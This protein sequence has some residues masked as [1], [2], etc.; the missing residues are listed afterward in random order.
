M[1]HLGTPALAIKEAL[2]L[3]E[4][5]GVF[6]PGIDSLQLYVSIVALSYFHI[7]NAPT[8]S[9]LFGINLASGQWKIQRPR[10]VTGMMTA[11]PEVQAISCREC[12]SS[13][14]F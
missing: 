2:S 14:W 12:S 3:G 7:S 10:H 8:L 9:H 13:L 1:P 11:F 6:R 5:E 4:A